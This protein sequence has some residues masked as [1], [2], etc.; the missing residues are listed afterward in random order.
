MNESTS[1]TVNCLRDGLQILRGKVCWRVYCSSATGTALDI[2]F[3]P[4]AVR[5]HPLKNPMFSELE[6]THAGMFGLFV[7][8]AWRL[9]TCDR[10][11]SASGVTESSGELLLEVVR[12]LQGRTIEAI[13]EPS[14]PGNDIT[15]RFSEG[16]ELSIFCDLVGED[17]GDNFSLFLETETITVGS[18][19]VVRRSKLTSTT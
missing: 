1:S 9:Q 2:H 12:R 4:L 16:V 5:R 7:H 18:G 8:C 3:L 19:S 10:V 17:A 13:T 14:K 6:R 11:V 15:I